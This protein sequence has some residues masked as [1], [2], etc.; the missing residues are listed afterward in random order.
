MGFPLVKCWEDTRDRGRGERGLLAHEV[1]W[2]LGPPPPGRAA[3]AAMHPQAFGAQLSLRA[4]P[5]LGGQQPAHQP[6]RSRRAGETAL[7]GV[8]TEPVGRTNVPALGECKGGF[9]QPRIPLFSNYKCTGCVSP[10]LI[11]DYSVGC[12]GQMTWFIYF[13]FSLPGQPSSAKSA[14]CSCRVVPPPLYFMK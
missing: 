10:R 8:E 14:F 11:R 3:A 7:A 12:S 5:R 2:F 9:P 13:I 4:S 6:A 1:G